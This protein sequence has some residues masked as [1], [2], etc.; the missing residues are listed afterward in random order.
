M[1]KEKQLF[2]WLAE[3]TVIARQTRG[4]LQKVKGEMEE[5]RYR[6]KNDPFRA[7]GGESTLSV[8]ALGSS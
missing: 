7:Q 2:S 3:K 8:K 1:T 4:K 5:E 6:V